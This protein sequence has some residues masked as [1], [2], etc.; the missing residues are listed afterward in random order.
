MQIIYVFTYYSIIIFFTLV[1]TFSHF[2]E[3][4][5]RERA[6]RNNVLFG[7]SDRIDSFLL[8]FWI[9]WRFPSRGFSLF[10]SEQMCTMPFCVQAMNRPTLAPGIR[11]GPVMSRP[12]GYV[13]AEPNPFY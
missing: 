3:E 10:F 7:L 6:L 11:V 1:Q 5:P 12:Y 2:Y 4:R 8:W 9:A 13:G